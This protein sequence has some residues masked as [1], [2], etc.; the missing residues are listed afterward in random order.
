MWFA[1]KRTL[2][3]IGGQVDGKIEHYRNIL[4]RLREDFLARAAVTTEFTVLR[5]QDDVSNTIP[6][7]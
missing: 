2:E 7:K 1:G 5:I 3:N 6:Y 4:V